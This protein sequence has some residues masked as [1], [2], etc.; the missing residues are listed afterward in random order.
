MKFGTQSNFWQQLKRD[1][2]IKRI[3]SDLDILN[4]KVVIFFF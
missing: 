4:V 2:G 1:I 3:T